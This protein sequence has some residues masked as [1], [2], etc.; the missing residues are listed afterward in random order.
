MLDVKV[1]SSLG[2]SDHAV[3]ELRDPERREQCKKQDCSPGLQESK[4]LALQGPA[5]KNLMGYV[6]DRGGF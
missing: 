5:W 1:R 3:I 6:P 2:C 4:I